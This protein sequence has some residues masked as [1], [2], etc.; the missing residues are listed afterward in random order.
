MQQG[1]RAIIHPRID[2]LKGQLEALTAERDLK[3]AAVLTMEQLRK[4][5][6]LKVEAKRKRKRAE[7]GR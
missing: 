3:V 6:Q 7:V 1:K 4:V 5:E 2:F